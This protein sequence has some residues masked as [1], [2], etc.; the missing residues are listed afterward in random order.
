MDHAIDS[1]E[2]VNRWILSSLKISLFFFF[3]TLINWPPYSNFFSEKFL[4]LT[5][6][7]TLYCSLITLCKLFS[8]SKMQ[9][10][11][12]NTCA[13]KKIYFLTDNLATSYIQLTAYHTNFYRN[14]ISILN[15]F[16]IY[17]FN[18]LL[19]TTWAIIYNTQTMKEYHKSNK[20]CA[21]YQ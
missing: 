14:A 18:S 4:S 8:Y 12:D 15:Y 21:N 6:I 11:L 9:Q 20:L 7:Y 16:S 17:I 2:R 10:F 19:I 1:V 13:C 5:Q 3:C